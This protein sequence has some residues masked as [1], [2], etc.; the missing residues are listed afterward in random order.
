MD[1]FFFYDKLPTNYPDDRILFDPM[2]THQPS[3]TICILISI[4]LERIPI[5][6]HGSSSKVE[7]YVIFII[8][9]K[10]EN[11]TVGVG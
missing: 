11:G 1:H 8:R 2:T 6:L 7:L 4:L 3:Y 10:C 9:K 5:F